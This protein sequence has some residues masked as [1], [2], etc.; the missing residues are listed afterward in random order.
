[1]NVSLNRP[2]FTYWTKLLTVT[3]LSWSNNSTSISPKAV[4]NCA[5]VP[6]CAG[7][8]ATSAKSNNARMVFFIDITRQICARDFSL[9]HQ[10]SHF[11]SKQTVVSN[12][13]VSMLSS[14]GLAP[15]IPTGA[16]ENQSAGGDVP[17]ADPV[18]EIS[19]HP[20]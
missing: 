16:F 17:Q 3:G 18:F 8:T 14:H 10:R 11:L 4:R 1:M 19:V 2:L 15:E 13:L 20:A 12:D 5:S 6:A 9:L 7:I